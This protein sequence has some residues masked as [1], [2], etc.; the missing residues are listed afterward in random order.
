MG[1]R[2]RCTRG[3]P[4]DG[5]DAGHELARTERLGDVIVRSELE[6]QHPIH[7][8]RP[9]RQHDDRD[10]A[11]RVVLAELPADL[12]PVGS[13]QHEVEHD[14]RRSFGG[15]HGD[16]ALTALG[17]AH[18]VALLREVEPHELANIRLVVDHEDGGVWGHDR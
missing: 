13:R 3:P 1:R 5:T 18:G 2:Q 7:L 16:G 11:E 12:E 6:S 15:G 10:A 8:G 14:Q 9:G 17:L 4:Q